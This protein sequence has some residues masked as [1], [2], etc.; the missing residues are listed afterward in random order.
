MVEKYLLKRSL[1]AKIEPC[2]VGVPDQ[3]ASLVLPLVLQNIFSTTC[4][5][6]RTTQLGGKNNYKSKGKQWMLNRLPT[7]PGLPLLRLP[8]EVSTFATW[9]IIEIMTD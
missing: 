6:I 5:I 4:D 7:S 9:S 2:F 1:N 3:Q 8:P